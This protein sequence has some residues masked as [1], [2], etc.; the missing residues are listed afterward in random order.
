M[1]AKTGTYSLEDLRKNRF[2]SSV[3][4]GLDNIDAVVQAE[5]AAV[6]GILDEQLGEFAVTSSDIFR[7]Y[8][9]NGRIMPQRV[10]E[11]GRARTRKVQGGGTVGFPLK[12]YKSAIGWTSKFLEMAPPAEVAEQFIKVR[13]G[14]LVQVANEVQIA[15]FNKD[16]LTHYDQEP[17]GT[18]GV[19]IAVKKLLNADSAPIPDSP[20]GGSF[21]AASHTHYMAE[22]TV[23]NDTIDALIL[24]VTEH[25]HTKGLRIVVSAADRNKLAAISST[26]F[27]ALTGA[28]LIATS[29]TERKLDTSNIEN[30]L[31]GYW[32]DASVEVWVKPWGRT[33][34]YICYASGEPEKPLVRRERPQSSLTGLRLIP[35][36]PGYPVLSDNFE[37]EYGFGVWNRS[38]AAILYNQND[39]WANPDLSAIGG[40]AS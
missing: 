37:A 9:V 11:F 21:T 34:Y 16:N 29:G 39:T 13:T 28:G 4:F 5:L 10:D 32:G 30:Q 20:G 26:K 17:D 40:P 23:V 18:D 6:N 15:L 36:I 14:H 25:G 38:M 27:V 33:N 1:V 7:I 19:A 8:G 35:Q 3:A 2:Q 12:L 31:I 22:A 24:N